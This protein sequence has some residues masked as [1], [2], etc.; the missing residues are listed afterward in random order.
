MSAPVVSRPRGGTAAGQA[1]SPAPECGLA[2]VVDAGVHTLVLGSFPSRASLARGQYYAHPRN[3]FW[4]LM[5]RV[6]GE[7]LVALPYERRLDRL[8][9]H[10]IGLWDVIGRCDR[11]GS[12]DG[13]IRRAQRNAFETVL[14]AM[15]GLERVFFNGATAWRAAPDFAARGL[16]VGV[17]PSSSPALTI[18]LPAKQAAW[19]AI[20]RPRRAGELASDRPPRPARSTAT[21]AACPA[22]LAAR[23]TAVGPGRPR[24]RPC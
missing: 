19:A 15:P 22:G 11:P 21:G 16:A 12:L 5:E 10:G 17:L 3:H 13:D 4:P 14:A 9:A 20:A 1:A 18:G 24:L 2:P 7:P 23:A 6:L 8:L